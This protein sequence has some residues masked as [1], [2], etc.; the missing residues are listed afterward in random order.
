ML[1]RVVAQDV[2][3]LHIPELD[4]DQIDRNAAASSFKPKLVGGHMPYFCRSETCGLVHVQKITNGV[5]HQ[6]RAVLYSRADLVQTS[7]QICCRAATLPISSR[8]Q[9]FRL[10]CCCAVVRD[11]PHPLTVR[12]DGRFRGE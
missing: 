2:L 6:T 11:T 1:M 12:R 9:N 4:A 7:S 3:Q 8:S 10:L 5:W